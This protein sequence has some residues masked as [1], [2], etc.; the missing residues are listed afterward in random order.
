MALRVHCSTKMR[1]DDRK[2]SERTDVARQYVADR[3]NA[4]FTG[5]TEGAEVLFDVDDLE[6]CDGSWTLDSMCPIEWC[7]AMTGE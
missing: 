5:A 3:I 4:W 2:L 7:E 6:W 1:A